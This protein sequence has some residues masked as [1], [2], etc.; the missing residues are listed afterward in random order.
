MSRK[1]YCSGIPYIIRYFTV[2][3][4]TTAL[5]PVRLNT[6]ELLLIFSLHQNLFIYFE[7]G[8]GWLPGMFLAPV[9]RRGKFLAHRP[10]SAT[11]FELRLDCDAIPSPSSLRSAESIQILVYTYTYTCSYELNAHSPKIF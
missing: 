4:E 6:S 3:S 11:D 8:G 5:A 1:I 7:R 9:G 10:T 2:H